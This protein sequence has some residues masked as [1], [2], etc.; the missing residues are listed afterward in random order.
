MTSPAMVLIVHKDS[1]DLMPNGRVFLQNEDGTPALAEY[2]TIA[3]V[4][5]MFAPYV[6][7]ATPASGS[8]VHVDTEHRV[9]TLIVNG[10]G[11][12]AS[13]QIALPNGALDRSG[14][15]V[16]VLF[17]VGVNA[18]SFPGALMESEPPSTVYA[19][20][21]LAL[22]CVGMNEWIKLPS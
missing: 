2:T 3:Q 12:L 15:I 11:A 8:M 4:S 20:D 9:I 10:A 14:T 22:Q 6:Q 13:L 1:T 17:R 19:G 16:R 7:Q 21:G 18:L 5:A